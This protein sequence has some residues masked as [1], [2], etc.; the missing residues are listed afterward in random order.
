MVKAFAAW[1]L[2]LLISMPE[3]GVD[4][5]GF[6]RPEGEIAA[7]AVADRLEGEMVLENCATGE[8]N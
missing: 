7:D 6:M 2:L 3:C 1:P 4:M 5:P 8:E